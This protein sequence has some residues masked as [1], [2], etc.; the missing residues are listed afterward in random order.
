MKQSRKL[1]I[2]SSSEAFTIL[3]FL[4]ITNRPSK[5]SQR[6][7]LDGKHNIPRNERNERNDAKD[8]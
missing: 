3:D 1:D 7:S 8:S 2:L 4:G 6:A 5:R